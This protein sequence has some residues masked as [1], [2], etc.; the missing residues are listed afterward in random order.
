MWIIPRS[1]CTIY[2]VFDA[3]QAAVDSSRFTC[4]MRQENFR[5]KLHPGI[6]VTE[7]RLRNKKFYCGAHAGPCVNLTGR[8]KYKRRFL[9]GLDWVGFNAMLN[10]VLDSMSANCEVF[11]FNREAYVRGGKYFIR[12]GTRRRVEYA[13]EPIGVGIFHLWT[14]GP[15]NYFADF[16]GKPPPRLPNIVDSGTPG[17][18]C[19]TLDEEKRYAA[20]EEYDH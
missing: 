4:Q 9:E 13:Y 3:V 20:E 8:P 18:P 1:N 19:Y 15:D 10:D 17:Y 12:R 11:S 7:V 16:C 6:K 5:N 14:Q 2:G